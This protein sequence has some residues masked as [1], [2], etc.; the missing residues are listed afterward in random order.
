MVNMTT[1]NTVLQMI[2][3]DWMR[4]RVMGVYMMDIGMMP[5][6]GVIAGIIADSFG[7]QTAL[8]SG[9][10][11]GLTAVAIIALLN[12]NLRQLRI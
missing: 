1:N 4:G 8:L 11:V 3:P 9:A 7:V 10:I 2:T 6:G 5:L 12:P